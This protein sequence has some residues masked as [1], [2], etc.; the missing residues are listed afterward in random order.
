MFRGSGEGGPGPYAGQGHDDNGQRG[1]CVSEVAPVLGGK[2][3]KPDRAAE[4]VARHHTESKGGGRQPTVEV[5]GPEKL[6][7]VGL[8]AEVK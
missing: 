6:P 4:D 1:P 8:R 5:V 2:P 3:G 7:D